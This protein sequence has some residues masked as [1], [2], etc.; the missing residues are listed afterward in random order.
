MLHLFLG[1]K[2][3]WWLNQCNFFLQITFP[4]LFHHLMYEIPGSIL[5]PGNRLFSLLWVPPTVSVACCL[6][7]WISQDWFARRSTHT[8]LQSTKGSLLAHLLAQL[9]LLESAFSPFHHQFLDEIFEYFF[10]RNILTRLWHSRSQ[11]PRVRSVTSSTEGAPRKVS[12]K[13]PP[14]LGYVIWRALVLLPTFC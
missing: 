3:S 7:C 6:A 1:P 5:V 8:D 4:Y 13:F 2:A 10:A 12:L 14:D 9:I 11:T